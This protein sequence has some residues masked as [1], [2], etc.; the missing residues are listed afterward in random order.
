MRAK[1]LYQGYCAVVAFA[2]LGSIATKVLHLDP[3]R[4][5]P[6]ASILMIALGVACVAIEI[7]RWKTVL[8][9]LLLGA[10][11]EV[12]SLATGVPFGRY[13]Y[14]DQWIPT[15][16]LWGAERFPLL[17]PLAWVMIVG[18]AAS[19]L[20]RKLTGWTLVATTAL[21]CALIDAP[22]E[23]AMIDVFRYWTWESPGPL[24]GAPIVNS[25]G[26]FGVAFLAAIPLKSQT[27]QDG[28]QYSAQVVALFCG[29][30]GICGWLDHGSPAWPLLMIIGIV[31]FINNRTLDK[32]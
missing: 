14:T 10:V 19:C 4:V 1:P 28:P 9:I 7:G 26:W 5:K 29:F 20:S 13:H 32:T 18:G 17:L 22:M 2:I 21:L 16:P 6:I 8:Y 27:K 3:G 25:L 11:A 12:C 15:I 23:R 24:F 31:M 30:V